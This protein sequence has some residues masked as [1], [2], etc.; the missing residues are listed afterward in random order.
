MLVTYLQLA[1]TTASSV[2]PVVVEVITGPREDSFREEGSLALLEV[3]TREDMPVMYDD[4]K[5]GENE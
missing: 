4:V 1:V 3:C 5:N 2:D